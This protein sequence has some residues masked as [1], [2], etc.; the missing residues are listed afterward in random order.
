MKK[1][2]LVL[3]ILSLLTSF[4]LACENTTVSAIIADS[5][6]F[7][8]Q[9]VCVGGLVSKLKSKTSK[10]G[11]THTIFVLND[12][13]KF[14]KVFSTGTFP[15]KEGDKVMVTG[16]YFVEKQVGRHTFYNEIYVSSVG[17]LQ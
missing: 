6:K 10:K 14:L 13:G 4:S 17:K 8:G 7:D 15:I 3:S 9:E 16:R 5:H 12:E 11:K 1:I 2:S